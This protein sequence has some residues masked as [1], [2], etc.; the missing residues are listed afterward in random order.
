MITKIKID[1]KQL[2]YV[3][4]PNKKPEA[5]YIRNDYKIECLIRA[6]IQY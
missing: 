6:V 3:F 1:K 5:E 2:K 4:L